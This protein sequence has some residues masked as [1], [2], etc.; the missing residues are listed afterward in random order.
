MLPVKIMRN[1]V[2]GTLRYSKFF[3]KF[4]SS[5]AVS[6][7]YSNLLD[8]FRL[9]F[10][11]RSPLDR[12]VTSVICMCSQKEMIRVA[13]L[14]LITLMTHI[15]SP[16][17]YSC[18]NEEGYSMPAVSL[19]RDPYRPITMVP[20][21]PAISIW[22]LSGTPVNA[23]PK[24]SNILRR[25]FWNDTVLPRHWISLRRSMFR[26]RSGADTSPRFRQC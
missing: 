13:T 26:G 25:K 23:S 9:Q 10:F 7:K 21:N 14:R 6:E 18:C 24:T 12:G 16:R 1:V 20:A 2:N 4:T 17:I 8:L 19:P 3:S 5:A 11:S 22:A 15:Q